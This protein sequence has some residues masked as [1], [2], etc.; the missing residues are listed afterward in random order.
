MDNDYI[1]STKSLTQEK[2]KNWE[3]YLQ[4]NKCLFKSRIIKT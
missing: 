2:I 1:E 4:W 3:Q